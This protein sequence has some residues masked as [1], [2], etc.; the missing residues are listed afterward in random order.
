MEHQTVLGVDSRSLSSV[1]GS[2]SNL[3]HVTAPFKPPVKESER[4]NTTVRSVNVTGAPATDPLVP[5]AHSYYSNVKEIPSALPP[6]VSFREADADTVQGDTNDLSV[7]SFSA[8]INDHI[9]N[10]VG[11]VLKWKVMKPWEWSPLGDQAA[12]YLQHYHSV[13]KGDAEAHASVVSK[14]YPSVFTFDDYGGGAHGKHA[15]GVGEPVANVRMDSRRHMGAAIQKGELF[16]NLR[17]INNFF[18]A[19]ETRLPVYIAA[20]GSGFFS[21]LICLCAALYVKYLFARVRKSK[22][23]T[24]QSDGGSALPLLDKRTIMAAQKKENLAETR[25]MNP[26]LARIDDY[27]RGEVKRWE[28]RV[29][30]AEAKAASPENFQEIMKE[31]NSDAESSDSEEQEGGRVNKISP[32]N[33]INA[34]VDKL[35]QGNAQLEKALRHDS[36][37]DEYTTDSSDSDASSSD[38]DYDSSSDD[39]SESDSDS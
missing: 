5:S 29:L 22:S 39:S 37:S 12:S 16:D 21:V 20:F 14:I 11:E 23:T 26:N 32:A 3:R 4:P 38:D 8:A 19:D 31:L 25:A 2:R 27:I 17:H 24:Q 35:F 30:M 28:R 18:M 10:R 13:T 33:A 15:S 1:G 6:F 34:S 7:S 9:S 36:D